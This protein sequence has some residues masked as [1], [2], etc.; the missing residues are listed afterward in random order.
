MIT[1]VV[2]FIIP[3]LF[4]ATLRSA[5]VQTWLAAK[6]AAYL[7]QELDATVSVGGVNITWYMNVVLEDISLM[8][9]QEQPLLYARRMVFDMHRISLSRRSLTVNKL[10]FD[11][12][13][14]GMTRY[15]GDEDYNFKFLIDYFDRQ[16]KADTFALPPWNVVLRSFEFRNSGL[17]LSDYNSIPSDYGFDPSQFA[18]G[19]LN[20]LIE[21]IVFESDSLW[22]TVSHFSV[23]ESR[24]LRLE[25]L[26]AHL[27]ISPTASTARNMVIRTSDSQLELDVLLSYDNYQALG[28]FFH[29]V[30][31]QIDVKPSLL[32]LYDLAYF[33]PS[34]YGLDHRLNLQGSLS[35]KLSNLRASNMN[36]RYGLWSNFQGSFQ[37]V[38]LP[39]VE[40]TFL[41]FSVNRFVTTRKDL[42]SF[43]LPLRYGS[44]FLQ[45]PPES[46]ALGMIN[47]SGNFTGFI[48]DFVAYGQF[49]TAL[50]RISTDLAI[51]SNDDFTDIRYRGNLSTSGFDLGALLG[52]QSSF[53]SIALRAGLTGSGTSLSNLQVDMTG[54]VQ[55]LQFRG[56]NYKNI[57]VSGYFSNKRFNGNLLVNDP[58]LFVD[59][60]G[61]MDF[62]GEVPSLNF[63]AQI[64]NADLTRLNIYQRDSLYSSMLS[65]IISVRGRGSNLDNMEGEIEALKTTY[66]ERHIAEDTPGHQYRTDRMR[67]VSDLLQEGQKI[68]RLESDFLDMQMEGDVNPEHVG[69]ALE[70]VLSNY[71]PAGFPV[72]TNGRK[73]GNRV[74]A[75]ILLKHTLPLTHIFF[76]SLQLADNTHLTAHFDLEQKSL[77]VEGASDYFVFGNSQLTH[78]TL[79]MKGAGEE[80]VVQTQANRFFLSD[81]IWMDGFN[82]SGRAHHD[83]ISLDAHWHNTLSPRLN[84]GMIKGR[85]LMLGRESAWFSFGPQSYAVVNDSLWALGHHNR[86]VLDTAMVSVENLL[87]YKKDEYLR[88]DGVLSKNPM[89]VMKINLNNFNVESLNFLLRDRKVDFAGISSGELTL[90]N[91]QEA[92]HIAANLL[93][94]DFAFN[95]DH[96][97]DLSLNSIWDASY[98]AFRIDAEIIYHGNV[99]TNRPVVARG[100]FY[101]ERE[102]DNFDIDIVIENLRMSV[103]GRYLE[104]FASNF[105]G[106]ASGNLRLEGPMA[107]PELRGRARLMRTGFRV[108]YL[109]TAYSFAHDLEVGKDFF[110][111]ENL[112]LNDTLG[113]SALVSGVVRHENFFNFS[114]DITF[115]PERL[116]VLNTQPHHNDLFYGRAF[117]S[118]LFRVHGPVN[119]IVM[120]ISAQANRGTQIFLP[121]DYT[122][123]LTESHFITFVSP[124]K[125]APLPA[126]SSRTD[127]MGFTM[128]FDLEV[129]P[130]AEIQ[131]IFD[132]QIGDILRGRGFGNLKFEIDQQGAFHMY[133]DYTVQEGDYLFTLQNLINKRFRMEQGGTIRWTGDPYDA[134]VDIRALYRLRTSLF[135]L[136]ANQTDTSDFYRRRVPVETVLH[137]QDKLFNPT[138]SFAIQMPGGD[139]ATREM[140]ERIITT[141]QEMN[142][143]VFSLLILNRFVPPEDGFNT[144][145]GYGMG[146]TSSELLSNQL[147][148]WLS[149]ISSDFDIGIN[150]RP[151]DEISSQELEVALSTQLFDDRVVIDGNV[152]VAGNHPAA[153]QRAS[154]IIGD[155]N[156]E[157]KITPEGKFRIKAF[158]RSNTFDVLN[159]TAPYTQGVGVFYRREF[160]NLSELFRRRKRTVQETPYLE[161]LEYSGEEARSE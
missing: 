138:I 13:S 83:S 19:D 116:A 124:D 155:V 93:I 118:G 73:K 87:I 40:E 142:R 71:L 8:D 147:S 51:I 53:G 121:L 44:G 160:D 150:Y 65:T 106:I 1:L 74:E 60:S 2:M 48:Y 144:A 126:T 131:M 100:Y 110:R 35:G 67:L 119:N 52:N 99:G 149:Q 159:T 72:K 148:N 70:A 78:L 16:E 64:D 85:G 80:L 135:D 20:L 37:L 41:N 152:G 57:N 117:A 157:V 125:Q 114:V 14:V 88:V 7:S 143:Q 109:N 105:R 122:G 58:N 45:L 3:A 56:Y 5:R 94:R 23:A 91:L 12:A 47:F 95:H 158:N 146:S 59:F 127:F 113:N 137:L 161:E 90:S 108:D 82:F 139:E 10:L 92:P 30:D 79:D 101:P 29:Q 34:V 69:L 98:K 25:E 86:I 153:Q 115:R 128:N 123:E 102:D 17:S 81:S 38:G 140:I 133:G 97:G 27:F 107:A 145:L 89:D 28:D 22:A 33:M 62:G 136:A 18:F 156:V 104:A 141:E 4:Y 154:N 129:T 84:K 42:E 50:G 55:S 46:Q 76:P 66:H 151:G 36:I 130:E 134:D 39:N 9:K 63:T 111:F 103:F 61:L 32:R 43:R 77:T 31:L 54:Q 15:A 120:D 21:D 26:S 75:Q 11:Q 68:I 112:V 132:S 49:Q 24:G 6:A 96:L